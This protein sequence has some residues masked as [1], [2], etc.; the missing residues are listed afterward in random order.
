MEF[1]QAVLRPVEVRQLLTSSLH[2]YI[3]SIRC[4]FA[5]GS[6]IYIPDTRPARSTVVI[7]ARTERRILTRDCRRSAS[8]NSVLMF[9][10]TIFKRGV[11][12]SHLACRKVNKVVLR[13]VSCTGSVSTQKLQLAF[14]SF[15]R[16]SEIF[17]YLSNPNFL[18]HRVSVSK[19]P[20]R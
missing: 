1:L 11:K 16:F 9:S 7:M 4:T 8:F 5:W 10:N 13:S 6:R 2:T 20:C 3:V 19:A 12:L 15:A 18:L 14:S 17:I